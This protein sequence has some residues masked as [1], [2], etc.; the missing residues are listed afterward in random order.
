LPEGGQKTIEVRGN[1]QRLVYV[2]IGTEAKAVRFEPV[3]T[4]GNPEVCIFSF[5][6]E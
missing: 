4:W 1:H 5:E 2:N 3:S 6:L